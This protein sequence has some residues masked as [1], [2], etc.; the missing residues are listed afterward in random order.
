[1]LSA[2]GRHSVPVS[3]ELQA[4]RV[5]TAAGPSP[6]AEQWVAKSGSHEQGG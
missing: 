4:E 6:K 3:D 2:G 1:M 5:H